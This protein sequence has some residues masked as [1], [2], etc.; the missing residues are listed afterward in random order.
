MGDNRFALLRGER[1]AVGK[2]EKRKGKVARK[3]VEWKKVQGNEN[4]LK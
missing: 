4:N 1:P 3:D 2:S